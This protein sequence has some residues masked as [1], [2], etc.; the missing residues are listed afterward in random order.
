MNAWYTRYALS[1]VLLSPLLTGCGSTPEHKETTTEPITHKEDTMSQRITTASGLSYEIITPGTPNGISP[2]RGKNVKVH[3]TGWLNDNGKPGKKFDSS[4][5]R[6]EPF[7][8]TIGVGYVIKGWDEGVM[9][10]KTGEKR[11]L[12]IP[13]QLGYGTRG[14]GGLIPPSADLIFEVELLDVK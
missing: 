1:I 11:M 3:Y 8:F 6:N 4:K 9:S 7:E 13:A 14:A 10:M 2:S 5:D 12:Y